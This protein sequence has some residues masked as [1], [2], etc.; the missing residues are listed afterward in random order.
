MDYYNS[1]AQPLPRPIDASNP[2]Q[3]LKIDAILVFNDPR[4][5]ALDSTIMLDLL[6]SSQGILGTLSKKNGDTNAKNHGYLQDGQPRIYY[7]NPDLWWAA[8]HPLPRLGQGGFQQAFAGLWTAASKGAMLDDHVTM[9]GKPHNATYVFAENVLR[10]HRQQMV[11]EEVAK[12]SL[13]RVFMIGDNPLSDIMGANNYQ[14]K[15]SPW[16]SILVKTG[17]YDGGEPS[18][19]PKH[20]ANNVNEAVNWALKQVGWDR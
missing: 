10:D 12:N 20:I 15:Y 14:S 6:L 7:S 13:K 18:V 3:S 16:T 4:D 19:K 5:W 17:V 11:G 2:E 9:I 1:F 8:A